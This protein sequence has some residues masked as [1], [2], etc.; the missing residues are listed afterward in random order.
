[1][2]LVTP[3]G[4]RSY[5]GYLPY[6]MNS[7]IMKPGKIF[8]LAP[9]TGSSTMIGCWDGEGRVLHP[10]CGFVEFQGVEK[11]SSCE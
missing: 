10:F 9:V 1:M 6:R 4:P 8:W 11:A 2:I 5:N 7:I 3:N